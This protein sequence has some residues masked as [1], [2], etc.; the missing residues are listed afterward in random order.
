VKEEQL[1][2][3]KLMSQVTS[4]MDLNVFAQ[5]VSLDPAAAMAN[6]QELVQKGYVRK[7]G[8]GYGVTE[9][10]K[11]AIKAFTQAP[12]DKAFHFYTQIG[13]PTVYLAQSLA[14][15]YNIARQ[16][17]EDSLE[18]HLNR[19]DFEKWVTEVLADSELS[20]K[21]GELRK[22][23]PKPDAIRKELLQAIDQKY[24]VK[25]LL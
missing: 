21:I 23:G 3:L 6:V 10:G 8:S 25:D 7:G 14:D 15:F 17:G 2:I 13:Y 16:I 5:K 4:R 12:E 22:T 11:A 20:Q 19:E 24:D 18:F 1:N 9:K